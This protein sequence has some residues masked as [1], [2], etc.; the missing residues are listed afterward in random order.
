MANSAYMVPLV[1]ESGQPCKL[2]YEAIDS[3]YK[4]FNYVLDAFVDQLTMDSFVWTMQTTRNVDTALYNR[5]ITNPIELHIY[6]ADLDNLYTFHRTIQNRLSMHLIWINQ[7]AHIPLPTAEALE[8]YRK[9]DPLYA[10]VIEDAYKHAD[11]RYIRMDTPHTPT[12]PP[13]FDDTFTTPPS[14]PQLRLRQSFRSP[15]VSP[16]YRPPHIRSRQVHSSRRLF[17]D[18]DRVAEITSNIEQDQREL[19]RMEHI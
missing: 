14:S 11:K 3:F 2:I 18:V 7:C 4:A 12:Q 6:N 5:L 13:T 9:V 19:F 16:P 8:L 15:P 1:T 10:D 17:A